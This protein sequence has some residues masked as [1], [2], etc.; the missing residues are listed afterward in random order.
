[1]LLLRF[2]KKKDGCQ[3]FILKEPPAKRVGFKLKQE[4]SPNAK[5]MS[6]QAI[7]KA[8]ER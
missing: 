4:T 8:E 2:S 7:K 1:V 5:M 6:V 3:A